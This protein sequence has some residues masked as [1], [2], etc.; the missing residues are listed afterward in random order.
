MPTLTTRRI[1][2]EKPDRSKDRRIADGLGHYLKVA[3]NGTKTFT[4]R[5]SYGNKRHELTLGTYPATALAEARQKLAEAR[6]TLES[7]KNPLQAQHAQKQA[8]K[9]ALTVTDLITEWHSRVLTKTYRRAD[10]ALSTL[11]RDVES[12]I[13]KFLVKDVTARDV[14]LLVNKVVDR[15]SPVA[16]NRTLLLTKKLFAYAV[17]QH[18]IDAT[19]ATMT[20]KG[21]G[22]KEKSRERALSFEELRTV[23]KT[24]DTHPG[25]TSWQARMALKLLIL[26]GQRPGEV[27]SMEW[28]HLDLDA[29]TWNIPAAMTKSARTHTVHLSSQVIDLLDE[30]RPLTGTAVHVLRS[31]S[32]EAKPFDRHSVSH[33]VRDMFLDA[34]FPRMLHFTPHDL[35]RSFATRLSDLGT[36]PHVIEKILNHQMTGAMAV[37]NRAEYLAERRAAL[38][39]WGAKIEELR[40]TEEA[41][42]VHLK[43]SAA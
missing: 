19:P 27:T 1:D 39:L 33:A 5:Y 14:A 2:S 28:A 17:E 26:T 32:N 36:A 34:A 10:A 18:H 4:Y 11:K 31:T 7:G 20:R 43:R 21:A 12:Q 15:G 22:G 23:I 38:D 29:A 35:R 13:G 40:T 16:A 8:L 41:N 25:R 9:A 30:V 37:Y 3:R 42:V 6:R 24:L